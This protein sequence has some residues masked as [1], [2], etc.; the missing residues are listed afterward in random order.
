VS[1]CAPPG[2]DVRHCKARAAVLAAAALILAAC[3]GPA[4][5]EN[6]ASAVTVRYDGVVT[7]LDDATALAAKACATHGRTA[8]LRKVAFA[9]LGLGERWAHFDCL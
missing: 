7:T 4:L 1:L 8:R 6:S 9:G 2:I 5:V 3:A